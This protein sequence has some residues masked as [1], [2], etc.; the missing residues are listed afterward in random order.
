MW[1]D[2]EPLYPEIVLDELAILDILSL[3]IRLYVTIKFV[4][5]EEGRAL[6]GCVDLPQGK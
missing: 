1:G 6:V 2:R 5:G 4:D 3:V